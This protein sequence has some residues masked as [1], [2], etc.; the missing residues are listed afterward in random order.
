MAFLWGLFLGDAKRK[1]EHGIWYAYVYLPRFVF[2][3]KKAKGANQ[4][5]GGVFERGSHV[6]PLTLWFSPFKPLSVT[7]PPLFACNADKI[8]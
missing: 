8:V 4:G 1:G 6:S 3:L 5:Q 2:V 7:H